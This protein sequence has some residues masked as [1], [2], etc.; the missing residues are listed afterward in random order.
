[1]FGVPFVEPGEPTDSGTWPPVTPLTDTSARS[2]PFFP[3]S[4]VT[5][6]VRPP[7]LA[8]ADGSSS[9]LPPARNT[10]APPAGAPDKTRDDICPE[11]FATVA[12]TMPL[13][14][15]QLLPMSVIVTGADASG[16]ATTT[17]LAPVVAGAGA[18]SA[19]NK[20]E[21]PRVADIKDAAT[22]IKRRRVFIT[23]EW[24][25]LTGQR[26][27]WRRGCRQR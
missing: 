27:R 13:S 6:C 9:Q 22:P 25:F 23:K 21:L 18:T 14:R 4:M 2:P 15:T 11:R 19:P 17:G 26:S 10:G 7:T 1:M 8:A 12:R 3:G 16:F 5:V 24:G 20:N